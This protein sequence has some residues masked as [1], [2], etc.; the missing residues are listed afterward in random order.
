MAKLNAS[1]FYHHW[2]KWTDTKLITMPYILLCGY[3]KLQTLM[4]NF[5]EICYD[6]VYHQLLKINTYA[7]IL[8]YMQNRSLFELTY[9]TGGKQ[10]TD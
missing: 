1:Q 5:R 7:S 8:N 3:P 2:I 10:E 9:K 6:I 4:D